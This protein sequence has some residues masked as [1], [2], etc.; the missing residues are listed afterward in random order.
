[1]ILLKASDCKTITGS[2]RD[3]DVVLDWLSS[4]FLG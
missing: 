1:M 4:W 3:Q 2:V